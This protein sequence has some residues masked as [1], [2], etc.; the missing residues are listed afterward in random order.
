MTLTLLKK[1]SLSAFIL[2]VCVLVLLPTVLLAQSNTVSLSVT[3]TLF[4][5][6]ASPLQVW[7]SSVKVINNNPYELTVYLSAVN[8][9]PQGEGGQGKFLPVFEMMTEGTTLAEWLDITSE[10][11]VLR[12]GQSES[13]PFT[14]RVPEDAS[15]GGHFAA[16]LVGTRPPDTSAG[17]QVK[18]SQIVTSLFFLRVSGEVIEDGMIREFRASESFYTTPA[19]NFEVRF[20]NK[21]NVHIQ[22][23]GEIKIKNMWGKERGIIPINHKTHFGN[24]LPQS[25]RKFEFAWKGELSPS[26]IGR[27]SAELALAYGTDQRKF[28]TSK[29]YFWVVPIKPLLITLAVVGGIFLFIFWAVRTYVRHMLALQGYQPVR[30]RDGSFV[31][32]GDVLIKKTGRIDAPVRAGWFDLQKRLEQ[33]KA[34]VDTTKV[35]FGFVVQYKLFF[36]AVAGGLVVIALIVYFVTSVTEESRGYEVTIDNLDTAIKI[37]SEQILY[38]QQKDQGLNENKVINEGEIYVPKE[39][40]YK[41]FIV[42]SS[43]TPGEAAAMQ[44]RLEPDYEIAGLE[45]DLGPSKARSVIVYHKDL[46]AE[47][48]ELRELLGDFILSALPPEDEEKMITIYIGNDYT[49]R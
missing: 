13:V 38:D 9:A 3:P 22:P 48:L 36:S 24:V 25:I 20:E 41:L 27:Y 17:F 16:I 4:E 30:R 29:A 1:I 28:V 5:M 26:D 15:P 49:A 7:Q 46:Q 12:P 14:V 40:A 39:Q 8:F 31:R 23:Q 2:T 43:N 32:E 37:S 33:T 19:A 18:T 47:A 11:V 45:S 42:N 10:P 44:T 35:L 34:F 6:S 21:G